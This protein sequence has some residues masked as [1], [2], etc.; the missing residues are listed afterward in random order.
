MS[1]WMFWYVPNSIGYL[2]NE[3]NVA[4]EKIIFQVEMLQNPRNDP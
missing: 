1:F 4:E 3:S 2:E